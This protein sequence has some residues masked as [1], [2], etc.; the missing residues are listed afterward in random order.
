[1]WEGVVEEWGDFCPRSLTAGMYCPT[2]SMILKSWEF[3]PEE[4]EW[5]PALGVALST[6][7]LTSVTFGVVFP[8]K[9]LET[10]RALGARKAHWMSLRPGSASRRGGQALQQ[11]RWGKRSGDPRVFLS[12]FHLILPETSSFPMLYVKASVLMPL[13]RIMIFAL[14]SLSQINYSHASFLIH[15]YI[16]YFSIPLIVIG[17]CHIPSEFLVNNI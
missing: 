8:Q 10:G 12:G 15:V 11:L 2:N 14:K 3:Y 9:L 16:V 13:S 4:W 1:M 5:N 7:S 17:L 6:R